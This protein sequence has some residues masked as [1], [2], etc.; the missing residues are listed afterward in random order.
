MKKT[1]LYIIE[2]NSKIT[3]TTILKRYLILFSSVVFLIGCAVTDNKVSSLLKNYHLTKKIIK[4]DFFEHSYVLKEN[5]SSNRLHIY[6]HGDGT[7]WIKGRWKAAD[8]TPQNL[9]TLKLM[10]QDPQNSLY[11]ARPCYHSTVIQSECNSEL[12]TSARYSKDIISSVVKAAKTLSYQYNEIVLIG[13]SGGAVIA[14]LAAEQLDKTVA[15]ITIAGNLDTDYWAFTKK[16][17]PLKTSINPIAEDF[18]NLP[19]TIIHIVGQKDKVVPMQVTKGFAD[20]YTSATWRYSS[21]DHSC[22]WN[23]NWKS[24]LNRVNNKITNNKNL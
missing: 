8:P 20:K 17:K 24:I 14:T 3:I 18:K 10:L 4:T 6:I 1:D 5:I 12:W 23:N 13:Y 19:E 22:C 15:L 7:P 21:F 9:L 2:I 16:L 11:I